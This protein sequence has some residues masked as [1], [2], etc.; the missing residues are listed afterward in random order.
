MTKQIPSK[1]DQYVSVTELAQLGICEQQLL[2][3]K[4]HGKQRSK[5]LNNL[6]RDGERIHARYERVLAQATDSRCFIATAVYGPHASETNLL[7]RFRDKFLL[8]YWWGRILCSFY[9]RTS[10]GL[11]VLVRQF[12]GLRLPVRFVL[13]ALIYLVKSK[14]DEGCDD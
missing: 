10:P 9:Y 1:P 14:L 2:L 4:Y 11:V 3:D 13:M 12:P 6:A 5:T 8:P 7:R